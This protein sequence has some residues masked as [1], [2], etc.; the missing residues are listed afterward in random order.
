MFRIFKFSLIYTSNGCNNIFRVYIAFIT[1]IP[2]VAVVFK[3]IIS[4]RLSG[5][6]EIGYKITMCFMDNTYSRLA[7]FII[8][9]GSVCICSYFSLLVPLFPLKVPENKF[10]RNEFGIFCRLLTIIGITWVLQILDGFL[11]FTTFS[12][13]STIINSF[14]GTAIFIA[15]VLNKRIINCKYTAREDSPPKKHQLK[16]S[17]QR[18]LIKMLPD[19]DVIFHFFFYEDV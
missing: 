10:V 15:F 13:I 16:E 17:Q 6:G 4:W 9:V 12:Y 8:P 19:Y 7:S 3:V 18:N 11:P 14:Q 1:I 2:F 5:N